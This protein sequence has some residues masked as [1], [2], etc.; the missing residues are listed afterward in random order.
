VNKRMLRL[1][2][3]VALVTIASGPS[4]LLAD[5]RCPGTITNG[6]MACHQMICDGCVNAWYSCDDGWDYNWSVCGM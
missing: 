4:T 5:R 6:V 3:I 1:S 2:L